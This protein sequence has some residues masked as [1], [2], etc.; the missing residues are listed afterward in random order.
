MSRSFPIILALFALLLP[1]GAF[2]QV[3]DEGISLRIDRN[4][5]FSLG[6][7]IQGTFTLGVEG[8]D[9]VARVTFLLD[10][11]T[12]AVVTQSPFHH[13][14]QTGD[15]PLGRHVFSAVALTT[16][17][18]ELTTPAREFE[19]VS[20]DEGW[21]SVLKIMGPLLGIILIFTLVGVL[22]PVLLGRRRGEFRLAEYGP[23]GGA[24]CPRCGLPFPRHFF[25]PNLVV[26]KLERCPHCGRWSI[27]AQASSVA[28]QAAEARYVEDSTRGALRDEG[29][30]DVQERRIEDTK[31]DG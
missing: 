13:V 17:G 19:F 24:V 9:D 21:S 4:F 7:R 12:L 27:V 14:I 16:G 8:R 30:E 23:A 29:K 3:T 5:G 1:V 22:G 10:G 6:D 15:F 20:A 31:Y 2:A 18:Q 26:G 11:E 28:L 25:S